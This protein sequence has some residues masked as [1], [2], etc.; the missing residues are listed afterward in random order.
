MN[1]EWYHYLLAFGGAFFAGGIN[2]MAGNGSAITLTLLM[3]LFGL[4][5][6]VANA[7]NRVGIMSQS[8]VSTSV[9]FR[10]GKLDFKRSLPIAI[11]TFIGAITGIILV[12]VASNEQFRLVYKVLLVALFVSVLIKPKRWLRKTDTSKPLPM[13]IYPLFFL[14]GIYGGFIQMG[15]GIIFLAAMVLGARYSLTE[16]NG[17]KILSV[18]AYTVVVVGIFAAKG[19]I[20]WQI[21][22]LFAAGQSVGAYI[23]SRFATK[24]DKANIWAYRILI[25]VIIVAIIKVFNLHLLLSGLWT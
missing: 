14:I 2:T 23:M 13:W 5:P 8:L 18:G 12:F 7:T 20:D 11:P 19:L 22:L 24:S 15:M 17:I 6:K 21:G 9:F 10:N 1:L 25:F 4:P 16:S 3:E